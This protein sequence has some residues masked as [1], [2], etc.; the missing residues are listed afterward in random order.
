MSYQ[1]QKAKEAARKMRTDRMITQSTA[2]GTAVP[3]HLNGGFRIVPPDAAPRKHWSEYTEEEL[4]RL[5]A[6]LEREIRREKENAENVAVVAPVA[7][8]TKTYTE[9][10]QRRMTADE[11]KRL[12]VDPAFKFEQ[13]RASVVSIPVADANEQVRQYC[14]FR[15]ALAINVG[16]D[17][18]P[19]IDLMDERILR[20]PNFLTR[21]QFGALAPTERQTLMAAVDRVLGK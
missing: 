15:R 11:Y 13:Q 5:P 6:D 21:T 7:V 19:L 1:S 4:D 14:N 16:I 2:E 9:A 12:V 18:S 8:A 17:D 20:H 3:D 10:E